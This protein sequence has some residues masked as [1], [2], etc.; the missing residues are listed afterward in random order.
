MD[1]QTPTKIARTSRST[2]TLMAV[3]MKMMM[4][5]LMMSSANMNTF[6]TLMANLTKISLRE[7]FLSAQL[8]KL[9]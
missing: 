4:M 6:Q 9:L 7:N 3:M 8:N 2:S 1:V 5:M